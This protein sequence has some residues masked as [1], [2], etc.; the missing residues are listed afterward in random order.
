MKRDIKLENRLIKKVVDHLNSM[1]E[2]RNWVD[3][4]NFA[5]YGWANNF[6]ITHPEINDYE[7]MQYIVH[8]YDQKQLNAFDCKLSDAIAIFFNL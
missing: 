7:E 3:V 8:Y 4:E 5:K 6:Y 1:T 2:D